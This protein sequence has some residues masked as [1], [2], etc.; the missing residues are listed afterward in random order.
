MYFGPGWKRLVET[1]TYTIPTNNIL[2]CNF[3]AVRSTYED[4]AF[5]K[6]SNLAIRAPKDREQR[7]LFAGAAPP[8]KAMQ[9][10][11]LDDF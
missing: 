11:S 4:K 5:F 3:S 6:L 9:D 10:M 8:S 2:A 1:N 7:R